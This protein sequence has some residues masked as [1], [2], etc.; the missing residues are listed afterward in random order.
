MS[1][2]LRFENVVLLNHWI[3]LII[4]GFTKIVILNFKTKF[5]FKKHKLS[6]YSFEKDE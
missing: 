2:D 5:Q 3:D 6:H 4:L 1:E